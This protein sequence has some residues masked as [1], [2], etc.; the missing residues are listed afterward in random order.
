MLSARLRILFWMVCDRN[1]VFA[2]NS[3]FSVNWVQRHHLQVMNIIVWVKFWWFLDVIWFIMFRCI[4]LLSLSLNRPRVQPGRLCALVP[5][6]YHKLICTTMSW[7]WTR[8][9]FE[10][11]HVL[12]QD[13]F[14]TLL[15]FFYCFRT[16]QLTYYFTELGHVRW[17]EWVCLLGI[18]KVTCFN[19]LA[20][21]LIV[22]GELVEVYVYL[23]TILIV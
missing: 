21:D 23:L 6:I 10:W 13:G 22:F 7:A 20:M 12:K 15:C 11:G 2:Y 5:F 8:Q 1:Q 18:I 19:E 3:I 16:I 9:A 14:Q 17:C 4:G